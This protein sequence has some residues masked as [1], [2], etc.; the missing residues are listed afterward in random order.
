MPFTLDAGLDADEGAALAQA[1]GWAA[2]T[3]TTLRDVLEF[4]ARDGGAFSARDASGRLVGM[5]TCVTWSPLAWIGKLVVH[6]DAQRQGLARQLLRRAM[7]HARAQG[8][9]SLALDAS[10]SPYGRR[11][12]EQEGFVAFG[13]SWLSERPVGAPSPD[14]FRPGTAPTAVYPVSPAEVMELLACDQPRFGASRGP[15]LAKLMAMHQQQAFVA[16]D[17]KTGAFTGHAF[18]FRDRI[19]PLVADSPESAA[20]LLHALERARTPTRAIVAHWNPAARALFEAAGYAAV[21]PCLR[22]WRGP[23]L[24]RSGTQF[25]PASWAL[26]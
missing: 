6:P 25:C 4:A 18:A 23:V 15:L 2:E 20:W 21:R 8:A 16:V 12:Y 9:T 14:T 7:A 13:E 5:V 11:L 17:R 1:V 3:P 26:G 10:P 22:M 24:G 19:G